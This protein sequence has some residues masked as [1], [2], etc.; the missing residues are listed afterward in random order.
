MVLRVAATSSPASVAGAVAHLIRE[1]G[2]ASVQTVGAAAL[3]QAVKAIAVARAFM[4]PEGHKLT[5][6]PSFTEI[7]IGGARRTALR[8]EVSDSMPARPRAR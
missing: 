5:F 7:E 3:N 6:V 8:L 4:L 1:Q 2:S